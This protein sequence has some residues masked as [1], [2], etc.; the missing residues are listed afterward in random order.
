MSPLQAIT[1]GIIQGLTEFLPI[2]SSGHLVLVPNLL[3]WS[4]QSQAF[5]TVLH[6]GT[7][8]ALIIYFWKDLFEIIKSKKL[9]LLLLIGSIPA[10]ILGFLFEKAF[11]ETFRSVSSVLVFLLVGT[12]LMLVAESR[13]KKVWHTERIGEINKITNLKSFIIGIFQSFALFP[14][15]SRSGSTISAGMLFGLTREA[16]AR[17]SFLLSIPIVLGAGFFKIIDSYAVLSFDL[18]LLLGFISSFLVGMIAIRFLLKF[19]KSNNL[20]VFIIYR[21]LL[22]V[23]YFL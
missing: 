1:L 20:Y 10:G 9:I 15:L 8:G 17:F 5:D 12:V 16:A 3:G 2:S 6:F 11:E 4:I 13:Y 7:V 22:A 18:D 14:G 19:L 21:L 23:L